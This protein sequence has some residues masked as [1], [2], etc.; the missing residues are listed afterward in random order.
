MKTV[1]D[2]RRELGHFEDVEIARKE[3][4]DVRFR[5]RLLGE[6]DSR[7]E[8]DDG[9]R[10]NSGRWTQ[11]QL[12][13]LESGT[14]IAAAIGCSD[15]DGEIDIGDIARIPADNS[16]TAQEM[17]EFIE[18]PDITREQRAMAFWGWSWLAKKLADKLGW[19]VVEVISE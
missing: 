15:R 2:A 8:R 10:T 11:L 17:A 5:G 19:D 3:K 18:D 6:V 12:W 7:S 9:R 16:F 1:K 13:E 14:W 4:P